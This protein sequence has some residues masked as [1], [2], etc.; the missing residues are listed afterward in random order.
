MLLNYFILYA[1]YNSNYDRQSFNVAV[2]DDNCSGRTEIVC[3]DFKVK[4]MG[5][6]ID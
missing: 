3:H 1:L 4:H 5:R 2:I 6:K